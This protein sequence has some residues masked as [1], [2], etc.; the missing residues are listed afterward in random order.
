MICV[1]KVYFCSKIKI[2]ITTN[3]FHWYMNWFEMDVIRFCVDHL[4][5]ITNSRSRWILKGYW[6]KKWQRLSNW[7]FLE[8]SVFAFF[9]W[10]F[11]EFIVNLISLGSRYW[12][13]YQSGSI[14]IDLNCCGFW[15]PHF[16]VSLFCR[17]KQ[18]VD[19][20]PSLVFAGMVTKKACDGGWSHNRLHC[21]PK[22][23]SIKNIDQ[24][25]SSIHYIY[26]LDAIIRLLRLA[27]Y[28]HTHAYCMDS[29]RSLSI[30]GVYIYI[31]AFCILYIKRQTN[32]NLHIISIANKTF[33]FL[34]VIVVFCISTK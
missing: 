19:A 3:V 31:F 16:L 27:R 34:V 23:L 24:K 7:D 25:S 11:E 12:Y 10:Y 18:S 6:N 13:F 4:G 14:V 20:Y 32:H 26:N 17:T 9:W 33:S 5:Q 28:K 15:L 30:Y 8:I 2:L 1:S 29:T 22:E 21:W